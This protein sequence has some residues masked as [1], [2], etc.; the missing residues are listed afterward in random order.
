[1]KINTIVENIFE[2]ILTYIRWRRISCLGN[3]TL[4]GYIDL[5]F[6]SSYKS[7]MGTARILAEPSRC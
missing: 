3:S 6:G 5:L 4:A 1:M 7:G 2:I